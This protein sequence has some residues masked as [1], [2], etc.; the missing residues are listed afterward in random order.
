MSACLVVSLWGGAPTPREGSRG[1]AQAAPGAQGQRAQRRLHGCGAD[2]LASIL[3]PA[4][5][6]R[7]P[8]GHDGPQCWPLAFPLP[9]GLP[10]AILSDRPRLWKPHPESG[11]DVTC[12][13]PQAQG[14]PRALSSRP[15]PGD[16]STSP[17]TRPAP[18]E[19]V[20]P[21]SQVAA[22]GGTST[23][24]GTWREAALSARPGVLGGVRRRLQG[25]L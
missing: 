4:L 7:L 22:A 16:N 14:L 15:P 1:G 18:K 24:A 6:A 23:R 9:P 20:V 13:R 21:A 12:P 3:V 17:R 5:G 25:G 2:T 19:D 8:P 11:W 10:H